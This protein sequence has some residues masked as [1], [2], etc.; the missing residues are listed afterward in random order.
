MMVKCELCKIEQSIND[1]YACK[2][3]DSKYY[4]C[5][6]EKACKNRLD[7][8]RKKHKDQIKIDVQKYGHLGKN[9][10]F[11]A[12][13]GIN[14]DRLIEIPY[15]HKPCRCKCVHCQYYYCI[16]GENVYTW[17]GS[18][19]N[20]HWDQAKDIPKNIENKIQDIR[21]LY[22][23]YHI[24]YNNLTKLSLGIRDACHYYYDIDN[25]ELYKCSMISHDWKILSS[26]DKIDIMQWYD[27]VRT[28]DRENH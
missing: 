18:V 25:D 26:L 12:R 4:E 1:M 28:R 24:N 17:D 16:D 22:N 7:Q 20:L 2:D 8:E 10:Y 23:T 19:N 27:H 11:K 14:Y 13:Y 21:I 15:E 6:D 5:F 9:E 3:R